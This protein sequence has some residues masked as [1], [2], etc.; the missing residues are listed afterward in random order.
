MDPEEIDCEEEVGY[1]RV[2]VDTDHWR[3][4]MVMVFRFCKDREFLKS[5]A[6]TSI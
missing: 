3:M 5:W 4:N 6:N 1:V 2:V